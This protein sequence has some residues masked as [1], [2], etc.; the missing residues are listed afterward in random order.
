M[1]G[2]CVMHDYVTP[3]E[4]LAMCMQYESDIGLLKIYCLMTAGL[5]LWTALKAE[6]ANVKELNGA[7]R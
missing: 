7:D 1:F 5:F 3:G 6:M 4:A 2:H